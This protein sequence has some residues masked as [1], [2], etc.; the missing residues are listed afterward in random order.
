[1]QLGDYLG[2]EVRG[3]ADDYPVDCL[4]CWGGGAEVKGK[5]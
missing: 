3:L 5:A 2:C 4:G 1:M